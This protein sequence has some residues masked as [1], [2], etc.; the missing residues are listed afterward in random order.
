MSKFCINLILSSLIIA[1]VVEISR[2]S[3]FLAATLVAFPLTS[4]LALCFL[5]LETNDPHKVI[6]LSL[7]IFWLVLPTLVFFVALP[8]LLKAGFSFWPSL[9]GAS[10]TLLLVFLGYRWFLDHFG[11]E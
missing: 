2:R 1:F 9:V 11:V 8:V 7:S 6:H 4:I 3:T 10:S 5:Y